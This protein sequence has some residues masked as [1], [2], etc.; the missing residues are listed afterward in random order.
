[1]LIVGP[2]VPAALQ[3]LMKSIIDALL[4]LQA[5]GAPVRLAAVA[6]ATDLP[7]ADDWPNCAVIVTAIN[8]VA[9]STLSGSTWAWTRADG[10]AL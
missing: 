9:L 4:Q 2:E 5:P 8:S 7:A 1:M 6:A 10:S 3:P